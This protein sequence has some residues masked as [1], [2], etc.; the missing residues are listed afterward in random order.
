LWRSEIGS[1]LNVAMLARFVE[2][3]VLREMSDSIQTKDGDVIMRDVG[4]GH[5]YQV[6]VA[7][8]DGATEPDPNVAPGMFYNRSEA[9]Q[10]AKDWAKKTGGRIFA[11]D[12][13]GNR[14]LISSRSTT[15]S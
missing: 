12:R 10:F 4:G 9:E 1:S 11:V 13:E 5:Y 14:S 7:M 3:K 15:E 8:M 2:R 6:W